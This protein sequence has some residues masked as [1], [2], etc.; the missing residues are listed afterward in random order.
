MNFLSF[1]RLFPA[2]ASSPPTYPGEVAITLNRLTIVRLLGTVAVFLILANIAAQCV[3]HIT[4]HESVYGLIPL[5]NVDQENN[6][7]SYFSAS[8]LLIS[9]VLLSIISIEK[10]KTQAMWALHWIILAFTFLY[11]S[12]DEAASLHEL[13]IRPTREF[14]GRK[15]G[16]L[17]TAWVIP[18]IVATVIFAFSFLTFFLNL[19]TRTRR[20]VLL[21]AILYIG[22]ALGMELVAN[23][24]FERHGDDLTYAMLV[25]VEE[26]L[27]MAGAIV[28]INALMIYIEA[29]YN[30]IRFRFKRNRPPQ[31]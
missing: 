31:A 8:L 4:S 2:T 27:E 17:Y 15:T 11:L 9:A 3:R 10:R 1:S 21:A 7:P 25:T 29:N 16:L 23:G 24:Y 19:P 26:G 20:F 22:G 18:G 13:L 14:F 6:L 30:E 5:F 12:I 28:F